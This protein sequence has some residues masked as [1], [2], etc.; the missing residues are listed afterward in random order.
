MAGTA[1][2]P[3]LC[4]EGEFLCLIPMAFLTQSLMVL[5]SSDS[6]FTLG[7]RKRQKFHGIAM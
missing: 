6:S 7:T 4:S 5:F 3:R 2:V 1:P